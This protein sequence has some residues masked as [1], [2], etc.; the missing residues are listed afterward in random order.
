MN[1]MAGPKFEN[2]LSRKKR[3]SRPGLSVKEGKGMKNI[4]EGNFRKWG[5]IRAI[6]SNILVTDVDAKTED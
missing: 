1:S 2:H 3:V 4:W 6:V 5:K